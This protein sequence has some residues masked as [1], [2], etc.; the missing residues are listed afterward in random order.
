MVC[1]VCRGGVGIYLSMHATT[2]MTLIRQSQRQL[3]ASVEW[4]NS[5]RI[6]WRP[7]QAGE[8]GGIKRHLDG[9]KSDTGD[10]LN[11]DSDNSRTLGFSLG[12][13][14]IFPKNCFSFPAMWRRDSIPSCRF[15]NEEWKKLDELLS[16]HDQDHWSPLQ[17]TTW[18][19]LF[20]RLILFIGLARAELGRRNIFLCRP[21]QLL[22]VRWIFSFSSSSCGNQS[23]KKFPTWQYNPI[24]CFSRVT[25]VQTRSW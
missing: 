5:R 7:R 3:E 23:E 10:E 2:E 12:T 25:R 11:L 6:S 13:F 24:N 14:S 9:K 17:W 21:S 4:N 1:L 16:N 15:L 8:R 19:P 22:G 20:K 18:R